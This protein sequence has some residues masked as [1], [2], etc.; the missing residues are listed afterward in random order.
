MR[1]A[2]AV[3]LCRAREWRGGERQVRL[4]I[5]TLACRSGF[6]Q[7]LITMR[8]SSLALA[9]GSD[10]P[11]VLGVPWRSAYDP[12]ALLQTLL[13][14]RRLRALHGR[15]LLL[16]AHD[17]HALLLGL[18]AARV[19]GLP[20]VATRRSVTPPGPLWRL[21]DR[22]IAISAAVEAALRG[23]RVAPERIIRIPSA[24][25]LATLALVPARR[26]LRRRR[27]SVPVVMAVGALTSEKGHAT[28]IE[29]FALMHQ[30]L[31][32][33]VLV[34]LGDGPLRGELESLAR[35]RGVGARVHFRGD[36]PEAAGFIRAAHVLAQ[37]SRREAL[38]T[39]VLEAMALGT[40][41]VA[42]RTGGLVELL[43]E[44]A[45]LLVA[46]GDAAA[47]AEALERVLTEPLLRGALVHEA[48]ARVAAYDAPGVAD[49]VA[50]VYRS[51]LRAT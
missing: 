42:C 10:G 26:L 44:G 46:P 20:L 32:S 39:A 9:L 14:L 6:L 2:V 28:L 48:R 31:P 41:V 23:A 45:G 17:S 21:P 5:G 49:Q 3:H 11:R 51:A 13:H 37:P 27:R 18:L 40:P 34:L 24:V 47:L 38:G 16:H 36:R 12:R 4:L 25:S 22:I 33:A 35:Q 29:A 7:E 15:D 19:L 43:R 8:Y 1:G 50:E 30:R